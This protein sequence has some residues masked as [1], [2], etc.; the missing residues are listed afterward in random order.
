M[1]D[2]VKKHATELMVKA[3]PVFADYIKEIMAKKGKKY[4]DFT[5]EEKAQIVSGF[6]KIMANFGTELAEIF[7]KGEQTNG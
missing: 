5:E 3:G 1:A 6:S 4:T 7:F 2:E